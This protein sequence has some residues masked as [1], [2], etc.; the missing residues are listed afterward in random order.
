M[1]AKEMFEDLG[2]KQIKHNVFDEEPKPN[3]F[4]TPDEP[5]ILYKQEN[6]NYKNILWF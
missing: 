1:T 2:Y 6:I 3:V 5:Y 4:I